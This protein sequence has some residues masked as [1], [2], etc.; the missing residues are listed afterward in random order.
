M[1]HMPNFGM[2]FKRLMIFSISMLILVNLLQTVS[3]ETES[4]ANAA[5]IDLLWM[6]KLEMS[7]RRH[8]SR[9]LPDR[10]LQWPMHAEQHEKPLP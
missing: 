2:T 10:D 7:S 5:N 1:K 4:E 6:L 3:A 9:R 8:K